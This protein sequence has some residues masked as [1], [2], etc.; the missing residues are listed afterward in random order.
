[1]KR[2]RKRC[3]FCGGKIPGR[4]HYC[5]DICAEMARQGNA[6]TRSE[7]AKYE[8]AERALRK[9]AARADGEGMPVSRAVRIVREEMY[10]LNARLAS[11]D[12]Q[13][14]LKRREDTTHGSDTDRMEA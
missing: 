13:N 8:R 11:G 3:E 9:A 4:R 10:P 5:S 2:R 1:M 14:E 6:H 7:W 12:S